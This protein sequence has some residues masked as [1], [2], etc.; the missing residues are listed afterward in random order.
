MNPDIGI[1][2]AISNSFKL[3]MSNYLTAFNTKQRLVAFVMQIRTTS[4]EK[5]TKTNW[6][7]EH[8]AKGKRTFCRAGRPR[9]WSSSLVVGG[10]TSVR[11]K[12]LR[13]GGGELLMFPILMSVKVRCVH[14]VR[15]RLGG[16]PLGRR[17]C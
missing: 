5:K 9:L 16:A 3:A 10:T 15:R 8:C 2:L 4:L 11:A 17:G 13:V 12:P 6:I 14:S 7:V 1:Y